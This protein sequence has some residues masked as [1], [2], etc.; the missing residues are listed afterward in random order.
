MALYLTLSLLA[1][2]SSLND[3][4]SRMISSIKNFLRQNNI[5]LL[6]TQLFFPT[7]FYPTGFTQ[8]ENK[9]NKFLTNNYKNQ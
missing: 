8:Y 4:E 6:F 5:Y 1:I 7:N 9:Q 2:E 3:E